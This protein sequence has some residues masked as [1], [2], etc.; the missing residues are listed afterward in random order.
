MTR[1]SSAESSRMR[2]TDSII[3]LCWDLYFV[4]RWWSVLDLPL[5]LE[6]FNIESLIGELS[7][8]PT[9]PSEQFTLRSHRKFNY[10]WCKFS[11]KILENCSVE[12]LS[13]IA[14]TCSASLSCSVKSTR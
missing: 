7:L 10:Y 14:A 9:S 4:N 12:S 3:K 8:P 2:A 13:S 1:S 5:L 6:E 11:V